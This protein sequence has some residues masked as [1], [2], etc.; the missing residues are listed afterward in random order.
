[1]LKFGVDKSGAGYTIG[2]EVNLERRWDMKSHQSILMGLCAINVIQLPGL[3]TALQSAMMGTPERASMAACQPCIASTR[4]TITKA[5]LSDLLLSRG[6]NRASEPRSQEVPI[7]QDVVCHVEP[8]I[9]TWTVCIQTQSQPL[10]CRTFSHPYK[11]WFCPGA[12]Y[13]KCYGSWSGPG[14]N[15]TPCNA[16]TPGTLPEGCTPPVPP[17]WTPCV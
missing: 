7:C 12:T 4:P 17:D 5:Q 15:C 10:R 8:L 3:V 6:N 13:Y 2:E 11:V 1:M 16:T 14:A 9:Y